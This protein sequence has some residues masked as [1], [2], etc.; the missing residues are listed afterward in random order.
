MRDDW[1]L[2][3]AFAFKDTSKRGKAHRSFGRCAPKAKDVY[4]NRRIHDM[5]GLLS[6]K[7]VLMPT[8]Q[9]VTP[10]RSNSCPGESQV[11]RR[12]TTTRESNVLS[13]LAVSKTAVTLPSIPIVVRS[14]TKLPR[15]TSM[16]LSPT[17]ASNAAGSAQA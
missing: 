16:I 12:L 10:Q 1:E 11:F 4:E 8:R 6:P 17:P 5:P 7:V 2:L 15:A 14:M 9:T 3:C 13:A